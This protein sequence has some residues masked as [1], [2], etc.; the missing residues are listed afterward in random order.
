[1]TSETKFAEKLE[2]V[3]ATTVVYHGRELI[4]FGGCDYLGLS[5]H[6]RI[7]RAI[8]TGLKNRGLS[9]SAS[10]KTTGNHPLYG[11]AEKK[12]AAHFGVEAALLVPTGYQTNLAVAQALQGEIDTVLID[13]QAH[14]SLTEAA[15]IL[16]ASCRV[17]K[18]RQPEDLAGKLGDAG[19]V[20]ILTD[21]IFALSGQTAPLREY[22]KVAPKA[23]LWVDDSHAAGLMS[24][25]Q[26]TLQA[27]GI[28]GPV[29]QTTTFSKALG[30]Y[31]GAILGDRKL[32][33]GVVSR[34]ALLTGST[35]LPL[36]FVAAIPEALQLASGPKLRAKLARNMAQFEKSAG[37]ERGHGSPVY[38]FSYPARTGERLRKELLRR[39]IFPSLIRYGS[40]PPVFRLALSCAHSLSQIK[41]LGETL[42]N[43]R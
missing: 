9:V 7:L 40:L 15:A 42:R 25:G 1:M 8:K 30:L 18:H 32:M 3:N 13:E 11:E 26:G 5:W 14:P 22:R 12:L 35:P 36:P 2:R 20:S 39:G 23:W 37:L 43:I 33:R 6:P 4:Y 29:I 34:S 28:G 38:S 19:R 24:R 31:G 21:G 27:L 17:F 41:L 16:R 10:R